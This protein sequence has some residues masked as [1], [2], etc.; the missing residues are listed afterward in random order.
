M[1]TQPIDWDLW[2]EKQLQA[3]LDEAQIEK[4]KVEASQDADDFRAF[5]QEANENTL[6]DLGD[7]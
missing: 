3:I 4:N 7:I 5:I 1:K 2:R 6:S